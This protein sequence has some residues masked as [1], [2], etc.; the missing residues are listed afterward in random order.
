MN[1]H[2]ILLVACVA[3]TS[4]PGVSI[5]DAIIP[6]AGAVRVSCVTGSFSPYSEK[7]VFSGRPSFSPDVI[8]EEVFE[9]R[10]HDGIDRRWGLACKGD[11]VFTGCSSEKLPVVALP[12]GT[13]PPGI[14]PPTNLSGYAM[15]P[16][17]LLRDNGCYSAAEDVWSES[18]LYVTCCRLVA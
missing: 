11:W 6:K 7:A 3:W 17:M 10:R 14:W 12:D 13:K 5:A 9:P 1:L 16:S 8:P 2:N 18:K 4:A 15:S